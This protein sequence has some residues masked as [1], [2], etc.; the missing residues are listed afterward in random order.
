MNYYHSHADPP[1]SLTTRLRSLNDK[2]QD[3]AVQLKEAI[4]NAVSNTLG[5]AIRDLV[6]RL[7]GDQESPPEEKESFRGNYERQAHDRSYERSDRQERH[8]NDHDD[9]PWG[10]DHEDPQP[11]TEPSS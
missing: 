1:R 9:D 11:A 10:D 3:L 7:L 2:L 4:A 5:Q 6:R 8:W